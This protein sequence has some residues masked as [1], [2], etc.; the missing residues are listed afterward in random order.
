MQGDILKGLKLGRKV[1][2]ADSTCGAAIWP[3]PCDNLRLSPDN[4]CSPHSVHSVR[5]K[6]FVMCGPHPQNVSCHRRSLNVSNNNGRFRVFCLCLSTYL[7]KSRSGEKLEH[8]D[9]SP[10]R[11]EKKERENP[12][13]GANPLVPEPQLRRGQ[14][15]CM[16]GINKCA[17]LLLPPT[18]PQNTLSYASSLRS[19][20]TRLNSD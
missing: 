12:F 3:T 2:E 10:A 20:L 7:G 13:F 14:V 6:L 17:S 11:R 16:E 19:G 5:P 1:A 18:P 15:W 8:V 9:Y 4:L